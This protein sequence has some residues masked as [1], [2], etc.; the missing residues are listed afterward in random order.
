MNVLPLSSTFSLTPSAH[1]NWNLH[2]PDPKATWLDA[3]LW[4]C[5]WTVFFYQPL[6]Y[7]YRIL[8]FSKSTS[9]ASFKSIS[10]CMSSG[11]L[12]SILSLH[13]NALSSLLDYGSFSGTRFPSPPWTFRETSFL[14]VWLLF[15]RNMG[16]DD[17]IYSWWKEKANALPFWRARVGRGRYWR[18]VV[19]WTKITVEGIKT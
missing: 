13:Q 17:N 14:R 15:C 4:T 11:I 12:W 16:R 9:S 18:D 1:Q 3:H 2:N 10:A 7:G 5:P 8:F 6:A 19:C